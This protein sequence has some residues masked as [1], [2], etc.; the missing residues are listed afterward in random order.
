[1]AMVLARGQSW[2][3]LPLRGAATF[4][5]R[6]GTR[7]AGRGAVGGAW[8]GGRAAVGADGWGVGARAVVARLAASGCRDFFV[9]TWDEVDAL[10]VLDE[11]LSLSVLHGL[12]D[13]DVPRALASRARPVL[14]TAAMV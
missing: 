10:G 13:A 6:P 8:R 1:M 5:W 9:A 2:R 7:A 12:R 4:S 11:G 3:G 14:N